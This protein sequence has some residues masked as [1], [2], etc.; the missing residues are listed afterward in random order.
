MMMDY[1]I[2]AN[3]SRVFMIN[4]ILYTV[5][6]CVIRIRR[7]KQAGNAS[8]LCHVRGS[9]EGKRARGRLGLC[10]V[11]RVHSVSGLTMDWHCV[12]TSS[13]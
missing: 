3:V 7:Y 8:A 12:S 2:F 11:Q 9:L 10:R 13:V 4:S 5:M 6:R 1:Y